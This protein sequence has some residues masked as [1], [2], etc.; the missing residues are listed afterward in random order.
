SFVEMRMFLPTETRIVPP[1]ARLV[2]SS[3]RTMF[4]PD[5]P[6]GNLV[7]VRLNRTDFG[8]GPSFV[9]PTWRLTTRAFEI[10][11]KSNDSAWTFISLA[12]EG[13][14]KEVEAMPRVFVVLAPPSCLPL[15][16][17]MIG[18]LITGAA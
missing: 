3:T 1:H 5:L 8:L 7:R 6:P 11:P 4:I 12:P 16:S 13:M 9:P 15:M 18:E 10:V 14:G 2:S 17:Q